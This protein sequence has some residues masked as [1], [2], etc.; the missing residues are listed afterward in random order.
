MYYTSKGLGK[1]TD[2]SGCCQTIEYNV[3]GVPKSEGRSFMLPGQGRCQV[4]PLYLHQWP[5]R[6]MAR[7][8]RGRELGH[9]LRT[10]GHGMLC[11]LARKD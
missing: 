4:T 9:R 11:K 3:F 10:L 5:L 2:D 6:E 8:L 7:C 1:D